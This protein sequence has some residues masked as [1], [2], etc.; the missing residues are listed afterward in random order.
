[1]SVKRKFLRIENE[2]LRKRRERRESWSGD[3]G[4]GE[5]GKSAGGEKNDKYIF[6]NLSHANQS[7]VQ[8]YQ[9]E[10]I[11]VQIV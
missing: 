4:R 11:H 7:N 9:N 5:T 6:S 1:M 2:P 8:K 10:I 3:C